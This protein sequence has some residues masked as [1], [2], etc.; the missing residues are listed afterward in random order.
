M[1]S[2]VGAVTEAPTRRLDDWLLRPWFF[3][4]WC[5]IAAFGAYACMYGFRKPFT[6]GTFDGAKAW[7]VTSQVLGYTLSKI[8]GIKVIAEMP[9]ARRARVFLTL[10]GSA[11]VAL[12]LFAVS[13]RPYDAVW[14]FV[15]GLALG[16]VFGLVLG[17]LE[18]RRLTELFVAGLCASFIL[19][20]G[21]AKSVGA[22][23][24][25]AGVAERWMPATAGLVF[26][27]PLLVCVWMLRQIPAPSVQ[28]EA[29]RAPRAPMS[30]VDRMALLRRHGIGLFGIVVAYLLITIVRS[31]RADFAPEIWSGL[32]L[33]NQPAIF[34]QSELW[35]TLAVVCANGALVLVHDNRRALLTSIGLGIAGLA[36]ALVALA[37]GH[38][39]RVSPFVFMVLLG[40]GMYVPYVA[41]HT[42]IFERLIALT[43]E[44][45][46]IGYLMYVADAVGYVG[47]AG[48]VV[49]RGAFPSGQGFV[50]D[51]I[52]LSG[53]LLLA[54][55]VS[56]SGG[57]VYFAR[58][59]ARAQGAGVPV[60]RAGERAADA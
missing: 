32:G 29:A 14:L 18:G 19:A 2:A 37:A 41:V 34:T 24:L 53:G 6:V 9:A 17:F 58:R 31:I 48:V 28:D 8:I 38:A 3:T 1:A 60:A 35:V 40:V 15:N 7:L 50:D 54:A 36:L 57:W 30:G 44:Q 22:A 43:R 52:L 47:Y 11:Q 21:V 33:G 27:V 39:G 26:A 23:L 45:G 13:R 55:I 10:I 16:M 5:V 20:D 46:N 49:A 12:L 51:F 59:T 42:T 4:L 56:M 25:R